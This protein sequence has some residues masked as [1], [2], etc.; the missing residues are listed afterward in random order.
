M[1]YAQRDRE[2]EREEGEE[3]DTHCLENEVCGHGVVSP[4]QHYPD[5][6]H[7]RRLNR[8][9]NLFMLSTWKATKKT[10]LGKRNE[11]G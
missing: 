4:N 11:K 1:F 3:K 2:R 8:E 10:V 9:K 6:C 7:T 5:E